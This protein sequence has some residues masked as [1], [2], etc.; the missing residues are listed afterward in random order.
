M[1]HTLSEEEFLVFVNNPESVLPLF[2]N[3]IWEDFDYVLTVWDFNQEEKYAQLTDFEPNP[4]PDCSVT[5]YV[6]I[7]DISIENNYREVEFNNEYML[8]FGYTCPMD[9]MNF[10]S[11]YCTA[12]DTRSGSPVEVVD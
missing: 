7:V 4:H 9:N 12:W 11:I 3:T 1:K 6:N 8:N 10:Y 5:G 2:S